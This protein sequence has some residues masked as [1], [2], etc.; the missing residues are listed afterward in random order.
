M[1]N[2]NSGY[3]GYSMSNNAANAYENGE[4]PLSKWTKEDIIDDVKYIAENYNVNFDIN[5]LKKYAKETLKNAFL[6]QSSWHHTSLYCNKTYFYSIDEDKIVVI[7]DEDLKNLER[8]RK[9]KCKTENIKRQT[10]EVWECEFIEWSGT[11]KHP[12]ANKVIESGIIKGNW[13]YRNSGGK[14][15]INANGFIKIKKLN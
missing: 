9:D 10:E 13:F 11:R 7:T 3:S 6:K 14:K 8:E 5:S 15:S 12:K 4:M 2:M 1:I